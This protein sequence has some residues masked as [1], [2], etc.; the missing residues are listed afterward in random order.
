[1][2]PA[3]DP[4]PAEGQTQD[5]EVD[6]DGSFPRPP[7]P[8]SRK[9]DDLLMGSEVIGVESDLAHLTVLSPRGPEGRVRKPPIRRHSPSSFVVTGRH[10][11]WVPPELLRRR[12][13]AA[14]PDEEGPIEPTTSEDSGMTLLQ[15][16]F[17]QFVTHCT[18]LYCNILVDLSALK[19][20]HYCYT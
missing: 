10:F 15:G 5:M 6:D 13:E 9:D 8:V 4:P 16:L 14:V 11:S 18:Y 7:S 17:L 19:A 2:T 12:R 1:M 20:A 3:S